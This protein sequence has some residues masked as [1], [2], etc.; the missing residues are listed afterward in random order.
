ML[1]AGDITTFNDAQAPPGGSHWVGSHGPTTEL[2]I[3]SYEPSWPAQ[4]EI[5]ASQTRAALGHPRAVVV[6]ASLG[7]SVGARVQPARVV[8]RLS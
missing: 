6:R 8:A 7:S 1:R 5:L 3:V 4:Y 2:M